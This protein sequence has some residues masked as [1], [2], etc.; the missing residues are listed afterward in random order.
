[1]S[2]C[3]RSGLGTRLK[4]FATVSDVPIYT[5]RCLTLSYEESRH[6]ALVVFIHLGWTISLL[7]R[8]LII[9]W[10]KFK[11]LN[12]IYYSIISYGVDNCRN[13]R[14]NICWYASFGLRGNGST[15]NQYSGTEGKFCPLRQSLRLRVISGSQF[16]K[17][18]SFFGKAISLILIIIIQTV[19]SWVKFSEWSDLTFTVCARSG[20]TG[21]WTSRKLGRLR[22]KI[23]PNFL[24]RSR[25]Y[26]QIFEEWSLQFLMDYL[27]R[28]PVFSCFSN[29]C[30]KK[31]Y[32]FSQFSLAT[33][34]WHY[35]VWSGAW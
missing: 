10:S 2:S 14:S 25:I 29:F 31:I 8:W 22:V 13:F 3:A 5:S 20:E 34:S 18:N 4:F 12:F 19:F 17:I 1:M 16:F 27:A 26:F 24:L 7:Y 35:S 32:Q 11:H 21:T 33:L 6:L 28:L 30:I 9:I 23:T 15:R